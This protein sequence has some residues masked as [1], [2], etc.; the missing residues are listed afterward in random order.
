MRYRIFENMTEEWKECYAAGI[1]TEFMEQRG[2]GHTSGDDK[3]FKK[4]FL[5]FKDRYS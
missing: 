5:D 2:P 4:G 1:F 3:I